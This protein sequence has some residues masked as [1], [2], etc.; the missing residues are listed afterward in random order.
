MRSDNTDVEVLLI[1]NASKG[2]FHSSLVYMHAGQGIREIYVPINTT[3]EKPGKDM[4]N[5]LQTC[6]G[7]TGCDTTSSLYRTGQTT[8][9]TKLKTHPS[10]LKDL[11]L[12]GLCGGLEESLPA[13]REF[14]FNIC[15][16]SFHIF[17]LS[18]Y[19]FKVSFNIFRLSFNIFRVLFHIFNSTQ[20]KLTAIFS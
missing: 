6:H 3:S 10:Q 12:F 7:L 8:A 13:A 17:R 2:M 18:F 1:C 9:F 5:C 19:I 16:V 11:T 14:N 4:S 15:E 20:T